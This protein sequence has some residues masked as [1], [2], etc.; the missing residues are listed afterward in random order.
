MENDIKFSSHD[1][2]VLQINAFYEGM[3]EG[4]KLYAFWK[5]GIQ[6]VGGNGKSLSEALKNIEVLRADRM[7]ALLRERDGVII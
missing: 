6:Y 7:E 4:I 1:A 5:D 2:R 3:K